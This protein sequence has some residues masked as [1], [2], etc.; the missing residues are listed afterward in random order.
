MNTVFLL[1]SACAFIPFSCFE[2]AFTEGALLG[3]G[4]PK[5]ELIFLAA[6]SQQ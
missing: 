6:F 5:T 2:M 1:G 4:L 3:D